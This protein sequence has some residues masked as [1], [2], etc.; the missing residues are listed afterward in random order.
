MEFCILP[1][2]L[3][4]IIVLNSYQ[5]VTV[6]EFFACNSLNASFLTSV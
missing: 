6:V 2:K 4:K 3:F 5:V 1:G